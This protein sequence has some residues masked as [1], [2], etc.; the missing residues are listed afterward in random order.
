MKWGFLQN[1]KYQ[2]E[3]RILMIPKKNE[4]LPLPIHFCNI[5]KFISVSFSLQIY[6]VS[7]ISIFLIKLVSKKKY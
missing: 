2:Q 1:K 3:F 6:T 4:P 7:N 5:F